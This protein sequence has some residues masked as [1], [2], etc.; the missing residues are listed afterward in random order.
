MKS[1]FRQFFSR[2]FPKNSEYFIGAILSAL[3]VHL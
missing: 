3:K 2:T 1:S